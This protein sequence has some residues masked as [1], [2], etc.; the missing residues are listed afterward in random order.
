LLATVTKLA[1]SKLLN[2]QR[3]YKMYTT[4][5]LTHAAEMTLLADNSCCTTTT[6]RKARLG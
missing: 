3:Y 1:I 6:W 5:T 2:Q 4:A